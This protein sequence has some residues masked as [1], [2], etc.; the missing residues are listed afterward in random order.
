MQLMITDI[1]LNSAVLPLQPWYVPGPW[2]TRYPAHHQRHYQTPR[3]TRQPE[4]DAF[5]KRKSML[6]PQPENDPEMQEH[7]FLCFDPNCQY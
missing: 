1:R 5:I 3:Q 2:E 7:Y 6:K 4:Q